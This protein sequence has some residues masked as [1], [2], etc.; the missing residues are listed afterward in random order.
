MVGW[1]LA[2]ECFSTADKV[3]RCTDVFASK[4][5]PTRF[6]VAGVNTYICNLGESMLC[7]VLPACTMAC[8]FMPCENPPARMVG[9]GRELARE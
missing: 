6:V 8:E 5:P 1:G 3:F 2:R 4:L 7:G 9:C